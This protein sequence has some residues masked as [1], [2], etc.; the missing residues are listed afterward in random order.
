MKKLL[1]IASL[2]FS[3]NSVHATYGTV[4]NYEQTFTTYTEASA[5]GPVMFSSAPIRFLAVSPSTASPNGYLA[6]FRSTS[7]TFTADIATQTLIPLYGNPEVPRM[8][9]DMTNTSYTFINKV[10]VGGITIWLNCVGRTDVGLCPGL[11][12]S[13][14]SLGK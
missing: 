11:P 6:I 1:L 13:G 3:V 9:F 10:G 2:L 14:Q 4:T 5:A 8:L 12:Y 7:P